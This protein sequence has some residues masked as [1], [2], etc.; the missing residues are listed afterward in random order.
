M[1]ST[2]RMPWLML[3]AT[4]C[5]PFAAPA[6]FAAE[7]AFAPMLP[8]FKDPPRYPRTAFEQNIEGWVHA[9]FVVLKDGSVQK[10]SI[11]VLDEEP[12]GVFTSSAIRSAET[13]RFNPR[14]SGSGEPVDAE[15]ITYLFR[16]VLRPPSSPDRYYSDAYTGRL[17]PDAD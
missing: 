9:Q 4:L 5:T 6:V 17:P 15:G 13:L 11:V 1:S 12:R 10:D 14:L 16:F 7:A 2:L 3:A 8:I